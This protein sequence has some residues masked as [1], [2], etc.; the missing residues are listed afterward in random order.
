HW[1]EL[2]PVAK[3]NGVGLYFEA[4]C[5]GGV[6]II[7]TLTESMQANRV[8]ELYGIINGTTNYIL[9]QM[10]ENGSSYEAA[11]RE[12]QQLGYAEFNPTADVDG[13]DAMY[14]LSI[15]SSLAFHTT[16]PYTNVYREGITRITADD[17]KSARELGYVI[18]LL[19]IGRR[20]G[21]RIEARV[22]PTFVPVDHPLAGVRG[23]FNA[24]LLTGD[25]VDDIMLYG[26]GA[27]AHP[28]GSAI[29]SDIV[30]CA[31]QKTHAYT[32]F[33]I[34]D[35]AASDIEIAQD[36]TSK[37]Y[38]AITACDR[39]GVLA[40]VTKILGECGVSIRNILQKGGEGEY[41]PVTL[42]THTASE[43]A[44]MA[45]LEKIDKLEWVRSIDSCIRCL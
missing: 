6:P 22:H 36:F 32:D 1:Y 9:T 43:K 38:L 21:N 12:A 23:S 40:S 14:K 11:L 29:V 24:V 37:Y 27:G 17:I 7:R 25:Y 42:L 19:A 30:F 20:E 18:K 2:E 35:T 45:A 10:T 41:A 34:A 8:R 13:F 26:R 31:K 5:V 4:S 39:A 33:G 16:V 44:V 15:L 3:E 28:T